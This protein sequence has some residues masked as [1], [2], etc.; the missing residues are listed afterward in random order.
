MKEDQYDC[1]VDTVAHRS[2]LLQKRVIKY[3]EKHYHREKLQHGVH[4]VELFSER[5]AL[6]EYGIQKRWTYP[7]YRNTSRKMGIWF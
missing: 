2:G 5:L 7:Y 6:S 4:M 1:L 3:V